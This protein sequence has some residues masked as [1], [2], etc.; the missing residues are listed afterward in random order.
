MTGVYHYSQFDWL[1]QGWEIYQDK[2]EV[3]I[4]GHKTTIFCCSFFGETGFHGAVGAVL[5]AQK[6]TLKDRTSVNI[7]S[8]S[9]FK[10]NWKDTILN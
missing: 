5:C 10:Y 8:N 6:K 9:E 7:W 1:R 3:V 2:L 4:S